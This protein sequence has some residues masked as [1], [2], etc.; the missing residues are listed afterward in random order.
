M[1]LFVQLCRK[2]W[3]EIDGVAC[4]ICHGIERARGTSGHLL[5]LPKRLDTY[6]LNHSCLLWCDLTSE[7]HWHPRAPPILS[8]ARY[9]TILPITAFSLLRSCVPEASKG[10]GAYVGTFCWL[11]RGHSSNRIGSASLC[12]RVS[13]ESPV[14]SLVYTHTLFISLCATP[15]YVVPKSTAITIFSDM[16]VDIPG[17][18]GLVESPVEQDTDCPV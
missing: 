7:P 4:R 9:R 11:T 18:T 17:E 3:C 13:P 2:T 14:C 8:E 6:S 12:I 16:A 10:S 15:E 1:R 5:L